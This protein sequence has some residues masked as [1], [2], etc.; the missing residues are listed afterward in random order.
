MNTR[1]IWRWSGLLVVVT[2]IVSM[3]TAPVGASPV[4]APPQNATASPVQQILPK[5]V[6]R[7]IPQKPPSSRGEGKSDEALVKLAPELRPIAK[8]RSSEVVLVTVLMRTGTKVEPYFQRVV[9]RKPIGGLQW[10][11]GEISGANLL[12]L[13][14]LSGVISVVSFQ[15]YA[16]VPAPNDDFRGGL[17]YQPPSLKLEKG[18]GAQV[19][20]AL[21]KFTAGMSPEQVREKLRADPAFRAKV[22]EILG[23]PLPQR[24]ALPEKPSLP[25]QGGIQ[26]AT[27]KVKDVHGASAAWTKGY[28]GTGVVA[29][30]VDTGVDFAH[31]DLQGTQAR[32]PSGP[33]AGWPYSYDT[34]SGLFYAFGYS[35]IGPDTYWDVVGNTYYAHTLPV[36]SPTCNGITCTANLKID[37]GSDAGWPWPPVVLPFVWPD[38]SKSRQYY[39]TVHPDFPLWNAGSSLGLGYAANPYYAPAAVIVADEN[40]ARVYDTVYVDADFDQDLTNNKPMRKGDELAGVDLYDAAGNPGTDGIWDLS[41]GMLAW[42]ADGENVPPG[43]NVL[44]SGLPVPEAG[45]LLAF[46]GD[47]DSHGTN[48][49]G[50]I[51]A[52]GVITDPE[53]IGPINRI[54]GGAA[55]AGG[56]GGPVLSG[57]APGAKIAAF[58][59]GFWLPFDSWVL[60][61]LGFDGVP[62]TGDEAQ[63]SSNSWGASATIN[64]GWDATSRFAHWLNRNYAPNLAFLVATGNGGHGYGTVTEPD[65]GSIIDVGASTQYGTLIY[66]EPITDTTM[67]AYGDVQP[68]SN[69]GPT[70]LGD[71]S[72]DVV[73]VGAWGT[74]ANPLNLYYG[75]GQAAYDIFGG[76]SMAT[77]IAAGN[78][79]LVYQAFKAKNGRWPTW[80]EAKAIFLSGATDLGYD[81][82]TQG[83]GNVNADRAT[84]IAAGLNYGFWAEPAQWTAGSYRGTDYPAFPAILHPGQ[85]DSQT[86]TLHNTYTGTFIVNIADTMLMRVA[87]VTFTL[88][89][90]SFGPPPFTRPTWITDIT[91]LIN[92]YEP[93]LIRAQVVFPY[94]VFDPEG[95]YAYNNRWRVMFYGWKDLNGD[96]NLW[97]DTNGN[98]YIDAGEIDQSPWEYNRF[99]YGYPSGT[100]LEASLGKDSYSRWLDPA[101]TA[102]N[103][104][105][106]G[107]QRRSG[108]AP[109][110]MQVRITFYKKADWG[111]LTTSASSVSLPAG[112]NATFN[113]T[114]SVPAD[115]KPG[116]Y[117]GAIEV[118]HGPHKTIIP[119]VVH[120]AANSPTFSFGASSPDEPIGDT[121]YDNG[122]L[123][124]GFDWAWGYESGDW[125]LY[126]F[127]LPS[128]TAGPGKAMVVDTR[129]T[130]PVPPPPP[131]TPIFYEDF[132]GA[133]PPSGWTVVNNGGD[134]V[135]QS[136]ATTGRPNFTGGA[137]DA[138]D[139]DADWCGPGTTMDTELRT[140]PIDLSGVTQA[141]L[142][143]KSDFNDLGNQD[144]GYVDIST[145]GGAT[146]TTLLHYDRADYRTRTEIINLTPYVGSANTIIRFRYV[147][148]DWDWWWEVDEV[149]IYLEEPTPPPPPQY[150]DVDTWIYAAA[151]DFY[152]TSD[153]AFFGPQSVEQVGGSND[154]NIGAGIFTFDTATGGPREV[155]A[156]EIR[157]GLGFI[158]LHNVLYAGTQLGEPIVGQAYQVQA[159]P[160]P[161]VITTSN[162]VNVSPI[163]FGDSWVESFTSAYTLT[164]GLGVLTFGLSQPQ[165]WENVNLPPGPTVCDWS[166]SFSVANGGLIEATAWS[167]NIADI[168]LYLF[169]PVSASSTTPTAWE[170]VRVKRP[171]DGTYQ[172]CVDNWSGTPGTFNLIL[173]VIQGTDLVVSGVPTGTIN[174]NTPVTFTVTFTKTAA[175]G[176]TWEGLLYLGPAAAPTAIEI[177]VTVNIITPTVLL[178]A[179]KVAS[180]EWVN[181]GDVFTYTITV[182]N[183]GSDREYVSVV[184]PLPAMVEFV[185]GSQTATKG[186]AFLDLIARE[187]RWTDWV[188]GGETVTITFRVRAQTGR[189]WAENTVS[190]NGRVSAQSLEATARTFINPYRLFLPLVM[191]N[192]GP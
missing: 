45:R 28:T 157:D 68:W 155:V 138:A 33:Y 167:T 100:Y 187:M 148:P 140:P 94:S 99:T 131:P 19:K 72:P 105:F 118:R 61:A 44:Y 115:A 120:V 135:W 121:P 159:S 186:S 5:E 164:E 55:N 43:T 180:T 181:A 119:V 69:R 25:P 162:V 174:A 158:A 143:F 63:I 130:N 150:T 104:I 137:G 2:M 20:E 73:A 188:N 184:D 6:G 54:F 3:A 127:D 166:Y 8:A 170:Q 64:D 178:T 146:W 78:L 191:R 147:A 154:T 23:R 59:H 97:T 151:P 107:V 11:T 15:S 14:G 183:L 111:W 125:K 192:Y 134:C 48:C 169:G 132:E 81:V 10:A 101:Q 46:I 58:Q 93:D 53:W 173:R 91:D 65:G 153:P 50:D 152:S 51:A 1:T 76:T 18:K 7:S 190:V 75:N 113:A 128:G 77:P 36:E 161:V 98:G 122:H 149:G 31:P 84:D 172:V 80:Q 96:G 83:S 116:V 79:A 29:A 176:T 102:G 109:V 89:F 87:E 67:L 41:A 37:F 70:T 22:S 114:L 62:N 117:E 112:G 88:S 123:F 177:P 141:W 12:K 171:P 175:P 49:A 126:Y 182:R 179:N 4:S 13:A 32:V 21:R 133:F 35:T 24:P 42:I 16:P 60:A 144:H 124:G 108:S 110:T 103:G 30:V 145:D 142:M 82:L 95:D 34:L 66:F 86:F 136:T 52:Q 27:I 129:W 38:T 160:A 163:Q 165:S 71:V 57:M 156:G 185:P 40:T 56:V 9:V 90:P 47:D 106:F 85:S 139:A 168:D 74:G 39:Y 92:T 26:P 17:G 189:G